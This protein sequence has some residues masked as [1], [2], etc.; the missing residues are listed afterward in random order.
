MN[1]D[2]EHS[3]FREYCAG[4]GHTKGTPLSE[5]TFRIGTGRAY[6]FYSYDEVIAMVDEIKIASL[7]GGL[8][9]CQKSVLHQLKDFG[10]LE[11]LHQ[12]A[13][14]EEVNLLKEK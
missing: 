14:Q 11:A 5:A 10:V 4:F 12:I 2:L 13:V 6:D 3:I 9:V 8:S 7:I 1:T